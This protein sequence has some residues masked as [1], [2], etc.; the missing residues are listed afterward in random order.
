MSYLVSNGEVLPAVLAQNLLTMAPFKN[1]PQEDYKVLLKHLLEIEQLQKTERG[2]LIIGPRGEGI[3]SHYNFYAVFEASVE[4]LVKNG[5]ESIGT[6][7]ESVP[8]GNRFALAGRSWECVEVNEKSKVVL[9]K[10][11]K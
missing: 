2:G 1:I 3:V 7:M 11:V 10:E 6:I 9:V 5:S 4:Y 8:V